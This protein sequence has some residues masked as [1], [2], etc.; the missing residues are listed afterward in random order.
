[1]VAFSMTGY[2]RI[3]FLT[4]SI[5]FVSF[6]SV[7]S[8]CESVTAQ[9]EKSPPPIPQYRGSC[10][11]PFPVLVKLELDEKFAGLEGVLRVEPD[12]VVVMR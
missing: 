10:E 6:K 3:V 7:D 1:M 12:S 8:S 4:F 11:G 5:C 2:T 9:E